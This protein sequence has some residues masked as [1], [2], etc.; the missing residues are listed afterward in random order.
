MKK[1]AFSFLFAILGF[2]A[3]T[4]R[5]SKADGTVELRNTNGR[6]D[7][8]YVYFQQMQDKTIP[9]LV[10]C[11][12]LLYPADSTLFTYVLWGIPTAG[13]EP[14]KIGPLGYGK[15]SFTTKDAFTTLFVTA[16][17]DEKVRTPSGDIVMQGPVQSI[18][19]LDRPTTPTPGP[20]GEITAVPTVTIEKL[21]TQQRLI[22]G[23]RRAGLI[24]LLLIFETSS[25]GVM[26][27]FIR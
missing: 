9:M 27:T 15:S 13:G 26:F 14:F 22:L 5:I 4:T 8:C 21:T 23:L 1:L 7:R 25:V 6:N 12:E 16:E 24:S 19:F 11:R 2:F 18:T 10:S 17:T 20:S 3:L